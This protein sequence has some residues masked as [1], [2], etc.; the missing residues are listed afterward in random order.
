MRYAPLN[1]DDPLI[2]IIENALFVIKNLEFTDLS[3]QEQRTVKRNAASVFAKLE[4]RS[5]KI[6]A[7]NLATMYHAVGNF[8]F[9]LK[10]NVELYREIFPSPELSLHAYVKM[11]EASAAAL[12]AWASEIGYGLRPVFD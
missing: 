11:L 10:D 6:T 2:E 8:R 1:Y 7:S 4:A 3:P 5:D 9:F 12:E